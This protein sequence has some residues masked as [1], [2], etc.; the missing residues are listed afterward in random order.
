MDD[1]WFKRQQKIAGVTAEDIAERLGR[2]RS[3]VSRIY[4]GRQPMSLEQAQVFAE[5][6]HV[7]LDEVLK[8]AG[9][10]SE[11]KSKTLAL[12]FGEADVVPFIGRTSEIA[13]TDRIA[14]CFGGGRAGVDVWKIR[15]AAMLG[16]GYRPDDMVLVDTKAAEAVRSGDVV[17]AQIYDWR[18]GSARTVFRRFE[19]PVLVASSPDRADHDVFVVDNTNVVIRGKVIASWRTA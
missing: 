18:S 8:R 11:Q 3:V 17:V 9:V 12:G 2:D 16:D 4:V 1:K 10:L 14:E 5:V 15:S 7:D 19:P 13:S 6:L